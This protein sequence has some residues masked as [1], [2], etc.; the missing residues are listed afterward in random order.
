[1]LHDAIGGACVFLGGLT[2]T[3]LNSKSGLD[4]SFPS[5]GI[6]SPKK[7]VATLLM[8]AHRLGLSRDVQRV[9]RDLSE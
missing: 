8:Y 7:M 9:R 3:A 5:R 1:M 2:A 4:L 6:S